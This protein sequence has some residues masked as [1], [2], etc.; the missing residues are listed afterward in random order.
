MALIL[1]NFEVL[2]SVLFSMFMDK[3][4]GNEALDPLELLE[5]ELDE[6]DIWT[7][8]HLDKTWTPFRCLVAESADT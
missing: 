3:D 2:E 7:F 8:K 1:L 4:N 5:L 6:E